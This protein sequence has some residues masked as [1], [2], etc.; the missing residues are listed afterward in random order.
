MNYLRII[1]YLQSHKELKLESLFSS[2]N[3][4]IRLFGYQLVRILG[5]VDLVQLMVDR[6]DDAAELERI[7]LLSTFELLGVPVDSRVINSSL[8][9]NNDKLIR[10]AAMAAAQ[11]G[12][13]TT[14]GMMWKILPTITSFQLK[15]SILRS[16]KS[17]NPM[18]NEAFIDTNTLLDIKEINSH[19][20]DPLL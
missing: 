3:Q 10:R 14:E 5:R 6:F 19:Q 16:L 18:S 7:E 17:L 11:I 1:R 4:S 8:L 9:T 12:D 2:E 13:E 20:L 15:K